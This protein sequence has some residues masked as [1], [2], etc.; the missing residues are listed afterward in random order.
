MVMS[1]FLVELVFWG[2]LWY[3]DGGRFDSF[4]GD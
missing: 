3:G 4:E 2:L 1:T